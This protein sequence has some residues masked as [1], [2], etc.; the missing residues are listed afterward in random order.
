[1][2]VSNSRPRD[3]EVHALL[4]EPA[5]NTKLSNSDNSRGS[6]GDL[7]K[8]LNYFLYYSKSLHKA[9]FYLKGKSCFLRLILDLI[10]L[11]THNDKMTHRLAI[12]LD[13]KY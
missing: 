2:W 6:M 13:L 10:I 4:T 9:L 1:M 7:K 8:F 11:T 3:Q 5:L 12:H